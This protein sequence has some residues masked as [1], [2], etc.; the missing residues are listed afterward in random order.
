LNSSCSATPRLRAQGHYYPR[1]SRRCSFLLRF[2]SHS[3]QAFTNGM[4][5][6]FNHHQYILQPHTWN[7]HYWGACWKC[8]IS[9]PKISAWS[10]SPQI[11]RMHLKV[12]ET[13]LLYILGQRKRKDKEIFFKFVIIPI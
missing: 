3:V 10:Q 13:L 1:S 8:K 4:K 6:T 12:W 11:I 9:G 7:W 5:G 2:C